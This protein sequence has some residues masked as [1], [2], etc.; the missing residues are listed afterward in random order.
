MLFFSFTA[1]IENF[2]FISK[3]YITCV[4]RYVTSWIA[5]FYQGLLWWQFKVM[6]FLNLE[7][8]G[9]RSTCTVHTK[10]YTSRAKVIGII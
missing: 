6:S 10:L 7:I 5:I 2:F 1:G 4:A 3:M 9:K 8:L